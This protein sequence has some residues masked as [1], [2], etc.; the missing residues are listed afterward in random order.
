[1]S[2]I[3]EQHSRCPDIVKAREE[4]TLLFLIASLAILAVSVILFAMSTA[5]ISQGNANLDHMK[6]RLNDLQTEIRQTEKAC[7]TAL[8]VCQSVQ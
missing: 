2:T 4:R 8:T 5:T 6:Y 3:T 1:M 7:N